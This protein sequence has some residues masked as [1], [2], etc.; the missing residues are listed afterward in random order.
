MGAREQKK[1]CGTIKTQK[2][3]EG[4]H[5]ARTQTSQEVAPASD[6]GVWWGEDEVIREGGN[7]VER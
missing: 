3:G 6:P 2:V 7:E 1:E 4:S 5:W